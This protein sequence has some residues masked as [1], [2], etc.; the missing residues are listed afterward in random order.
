MPGTFWAPDA[1]GNPREGTLA[2]KGW[3]DT[4]FPKIASSRKAQDGG[5]PV[6]DSPGDESE[7]GEESGTTTEE[8]DE[9]IRRTRSPA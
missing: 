2:D 1:H 9:E 4:T 5:A 3:F 8:L 6:D 7:E